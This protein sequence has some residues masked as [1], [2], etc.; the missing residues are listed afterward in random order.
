M[1]M[2]KELNQFQINEIQTLVPRLNDYPAIGTKWV[3]RNKLD[4]NGN[5]SR[6]KAR[7]IAQGYSQEKRINYDETYAPVA[8]LEAIG[9]LLAFACF[10]NFKLYQINVKSDFLNGSIYE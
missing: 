2:Q 3:F 10:K 8:R 5:I 7:L 6:N 4:E 9:V 1:A